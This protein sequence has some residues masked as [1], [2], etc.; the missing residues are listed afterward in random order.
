LQLEVNGITDSKYYRP[1]YGAITQDQIDFLGSKNI[2]TVLW[3]LTTMDWDSKQNQE[4]KMFEKFKKNIHNGAIVLLHDFDF[5]N[6]TAKLKD[7]EKMLNYGTSLGF[8]FV[9]IEDVM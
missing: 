4:G 8:K 6:P 7:L 5:G 9:N 2:R 3:S 1:P